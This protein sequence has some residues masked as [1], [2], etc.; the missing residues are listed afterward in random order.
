MAEPVAFV[1]TADPAGLAT[2][3][4]LIQLVGLTPSNE[5]DWVEGISGS[6][7]YVANGLVKLRPLEIWNLEYE[8][9]D[10]GT[11]SVAFG[12]PI[13]TS[14]LITAFSARCE[15]ESRAKVSMT[16]IKP[17]NANKIQSTGATIEIDVV[18]GVGIVNKWDATST[19]NCISSSCSV[20]M[21]QLTDTEEVPTAGVSDIVEGGLLQYL[22]VQ[23]CSLES[24]AAI[25]LPEGAI[26]LSNPSTPAETNQGWQTYSASW[27][28]Y[29]DPV[30]L[31]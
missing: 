27:K 29:L 22:F 16:I 25:V 15:V 9:Y 30:T 6:G 18:G 19:G 10:G 12:V 7:Q 17:S 23:E 2:S 4:G 3:D 28:V 20:S 5:H 26:L 24:R 1:S 14:Y 13:N 31:A 8:V 21:Q 11:L